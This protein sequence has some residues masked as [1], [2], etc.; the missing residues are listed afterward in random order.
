MTS[1]SMGGTTPLHRTDA[2]PPQRRAGQAAAFWL[3]PLAG[4]TWREVGFALTSLPI[5]VLS[6]GFAVTFFSAGLGLLVTALG[7]PV[8]ALLLSGARGFGALER[9]RARTLLATEVAGPA[10]VRPGRP[11]FWGGVTARL[12]DPAGWKAVLYQVL[13]FPWSV[14][15]FVVPTVFLALGWSL[16][17]YPAYHWVFPRYVGWPG[18]R[19]FDFRSGSGHYEYFISSPWQIAGVSILGFVL[20]YLAAGLVRA[21]NSVSRAAIR[22]LLSDR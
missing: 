22:G 19:L 13:M 11:G 8:L 17:L 6:F 1:T 12:A 3:A 9:H 16:A 15:S 7:L 2:Y 20:L 14:L 18:L 5:R 10:P 4:S 21:I